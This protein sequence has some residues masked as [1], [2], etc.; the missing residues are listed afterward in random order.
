[1]VDFLGSVTGTTKTLERNDS[2]F[3]L[4]FRT[5]GETTRRIWEVEDS[6]RSREIGTLLP[7]WAG[8]GKVCEARRTEYW[9]SHR[10]NAISR[11]L[12][13]PARSTR[14]VP[15][16]RIETSSGADERNDKDAKRMGS[17]TGVSPRDA[18]LGDS[19]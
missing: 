15:H 10:S 11:A 4:D 13:I 5:T 18:V 17:T 7:D 9:R 19:I 1:M 14:E 12:V 8:I 6:M 2:V 16:E 3:S